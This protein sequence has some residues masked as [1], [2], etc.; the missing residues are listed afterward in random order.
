M[1]STL[2][3]ILI[4]F[5]T[6]TRWHGTM[7]VLTGNDPE[8]V[9]NVQKTKPKGNKWDQEGSA[10]KLCWHDNLHYRPRYRLVPT[11]CHRK[12]PT[13]I[14]TSLTLSKFRYLILSSVVKI[15]QLAHARPQC[16]SFTLYSMPICCT[17][18]IPSFIVISN[19]WLEGLLL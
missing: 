9:S 10:E 1:K 14:V 11:M 3:I 16:P 17:H 6:C 5:T 2:G 18:Q 4:Q 7:S 19:I 13:T 12:L 15:M 8:K